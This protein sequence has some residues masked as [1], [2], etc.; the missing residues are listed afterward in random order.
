MNILKKNSHSFMH[1]II[2]LASMLIIS[3]LTFGA[4]WAYYSGRQVVSGTITMGNLSVNLVDG[5]STVTKLV[6]VDDIIPGQYLIAGKDNTFKNYTIDLSETNIN[7][8]IRVKID[9]ILNN[10]SAM[11]KFKLQT[12]DG[13]YLHYDGYLYQ[14]LD[15]SLLQDSIAYEAPANTNQ[16]LDLKLQFNQSTDIDYMNLSGKYSITVEAIQADY[17]TDGETSTTTHTISELANLWQ[18]TMSN[19][20]IFVITNGVITGLTTYAKANITNLVIPSTVTQIGAN[21]F[22]D[23][24]KLT[25]VIIPSSVTQIGA[26]AFQGSG[27]KTV[28]FE[29]KSGWLANAQTL[30][31]SNATQNATYLKTNYVNFTW[32]NY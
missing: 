5:T 4:V 26:G 3:C 32:T 7:T 28:S 25:S 16:T 23:C 15:T 31:L 9:V 27:I 18:P 21:A 13:W 11:D 24:D 20:D 8:F 12:H 6:A 19:D 10:I 22:K 2:L 14:S 17:L 1:I 29:D 30:D